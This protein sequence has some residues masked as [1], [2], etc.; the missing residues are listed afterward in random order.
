MK[1][2]QECHNLPNSFNFYFQHPTTVEVHKKKD[3]R[4]FNLF[5]LKH[6]SLHSSRLNVI[7]YL[8][9]FICDQKN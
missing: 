7:H 5:L 2:Q 8:S 9:P 4:N 1:T 3:F 6:N